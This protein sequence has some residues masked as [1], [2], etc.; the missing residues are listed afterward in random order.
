MDR[1]LCS[2]LD[3]PNSSLDRRTFLR[4]A[5][6]V[7]GTVALTNAVAAADIGAEGYEPL[8][9]VEVPDAREAVVG[10]DDYVY[11]ATVGGYAVVDVSSPSEPEVVAGRR[12]IT[13]GD[14]D[15]LT[16]IWDVKYADEKLLVAGQGPFRDDDVGVSGFVVED[17]SDP[18]N[19]T[20]L[21]GRETEFSIHNCV[22]D[23]TTAFL[24]SGPD[25]R[26][27]ITMFDVR[28]EE[29]TELGSW[30]VVDVAPEWADVY[31]RGGP[32]AHDLWVQQ[33]D[34]RA[35]AF[36]ACWD[37]G[38]WIVDVSDPGDPS[39]VGQAGGMDPQRVIELRDEGK[40]EGLMPPGNAHYTATN[41]DATLLGIGGESWAFETEDGIE[42]G[43]SGI[44]LYDISDPTAP[45]Q[46][47][48]IEP[49]ESPDPTLGGVDTT[50]H[51]FEFN[52]GILYSSWYR[53]GVKRH[54]VSSPANPRELT[55]WQQPEAASMW[56]ARVLTPGETFLASSIPIR[57]TGARGG[58]YVFPDADGAGGVPFRAT[59][60][61]TAT[62][63][64]S[65]TP[66]DATEKSNSRR[67]PTETETEP[68]GGDGDGTGGSGETDDGGAS[69]NAGTD[70]ADNETTATTAPG[71]GV[72]PT[73]AAA[74][75]VALGRLLG[76]GS[77]TSESERFE[78]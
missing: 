77:H 49:P 26:D 8:G 24:T 20:R 59:E 34:D 60:T 38:V 62:P 52:D 56:T 76:D 16:R 50:A 14:G 18:T 33:L 75:L 1:S 73:G 10:A 69:D 32:T 74:G 29:P 17:V 44:D 72:L 11:V 21:L 28:S 22:F 31:D 12:G 64:A 78:K 39:F 48:S 61:P 27:A 66:A 71:F 42:G 6:G 30:A 25:A 40:K 35:L 58:L 65:E 13:P 51:N 3:C 54:D 19:P 53:A 7:A 47:S 9:F 37:S 63:T 36:L 67:S 43:P 68:A 2:S 15:S 4:A 5:T 23:G 55:H 41:D 70:D 57:D 46:L 45:E